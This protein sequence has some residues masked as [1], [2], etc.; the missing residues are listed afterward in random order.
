MDFFAFP[1]CPKVS[2]ELVKFLD[3]AFPNRCPDITAS[4]RA[5]WMAAGAAKVVEGLKAALLS[6]QPAA[7]KDPQDVLLQS[8][9]EGTGSATGSSN[10]IPAGSGNRG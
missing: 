7:T 4:E 5:I 10:R 8:D 9:D 6:Q 2:P 3:E 1:L